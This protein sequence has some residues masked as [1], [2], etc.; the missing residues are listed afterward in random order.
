MSLRNLTKE[1]I[2]CKRVRKPAPT[3]NIYVCLLWP[4]KDNNIGPLV[5]TCDA[6]GAGLMVAREPGMRKLV[7]SGNTIGKDK[8][9]IQYISDPIALL[10]QESH[11]GS[12]IIAIELAKDSKPIEE[13]AF[14]NERT[15]ILLG[16]ES[17]GIPDD[18]W[19]FVHEAYEIPQAGVGNCLNVAVA[20]SI[21]LYEFTRGTIE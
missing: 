19:D 12:S 2:R 21:A 16:H 18:A 13:L 3:T 14:V 7:A 1:E 15:L 8:V 10:E 20:G 17:L 9:D 6:F 4:K 5:R 11:S